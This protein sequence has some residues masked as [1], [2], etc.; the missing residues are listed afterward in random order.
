MAYSKESILSGV[1]VKPRS[2]KAEAEVKMPLHKLVVE[3]I[4]EEV[5]TYH[6]VLLKPSCSA[7][8]PH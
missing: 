4:A 8:G 2:L 1:R 3:D 6:Q 5:L 7:S